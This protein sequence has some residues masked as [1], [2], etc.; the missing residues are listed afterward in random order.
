[1]II[2]LVLLYYYIIYSLVKG[3]SGWESLEGNLARQSEVVCVPVSKGNY[4]K[5]VNGMMKI[6]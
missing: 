4:P 6:S 5:I 3:L 1:M 2:T